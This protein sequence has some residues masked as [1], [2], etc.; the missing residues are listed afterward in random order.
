MNDVQV[1]YLSLEKNN[2]SEVNEDL[3]TAAVMRLTTA[4][5]RWANLSCQQVVNISSLLSFADFFLHIFCGILVNILY[6]LF[7]PLEL[8]G[9]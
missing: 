5:L 1:Q 9:D 2:L 8:S 4:D 7:S 6:Q 3:L